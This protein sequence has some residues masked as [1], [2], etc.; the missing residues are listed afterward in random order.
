MIKHANLFFKQDTPYT[1]PYAYI[2]YAHIYCIP[3][4]R[5]MHMHALQNKASSLGGAL[6]HSALRYI[7]LRSICGSDLL[8]LAGLGCLYVFRE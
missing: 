1:W 6:Q 2:P 7:L 4:Y 8:D 5:S 3:I